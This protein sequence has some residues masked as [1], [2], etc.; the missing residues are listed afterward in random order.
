MLTQSLG[1]TCVTGTAAVVCLAGDSQHLTVRHQHHQPPINGKWRQ[2]WV[3]SW[4]SFQLRGCSALNF[5]GDPPQRWH[6]AWKHSRCANLSIFQALF[7]LKL[8]FVPVHNK[9]TVKTM[10]SPTSLWHVPGELI[11]VHAEKG[12]T[13]FGLL[14]YSCLCYENAAMLQIWFVGLLMFMLWKCCHASNLVCWSTHVYAMKMLSCFKFGLLVYSCLCYENAAMLQIW[15]VGLLMFMLWKC[16]HAS[17]LVCWSTHV[18]AMKMLP[19]FKFGL[20][21]YSCLGY[22]NAAMLQIW[23]VGLLM[24]MLWECCHASNLVCWSTHVYAMRMLPCFKFGLLVYSCLCYENAAMLQIWFVGLL[25]FMLWECC[26]ASNLVC[27]STHVYAMKMLPC[28]KFELLVVLPCLG[29]HAFPWQPF[30]PA[31]ELI[32]AWIRSHKVQ[33]RHKSHTVTL[34]WHACKCKLHK[35]HSTH[36]HARW[37]LP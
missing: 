14:V 37:E 25:M 24:F 30:Q 20:L 27:W 36:A 7:W 12:N 28:F 18:Y 19:C 3:V 31:R 11:Y 2:R 6:V 4:L 29:A 15:F 35:L 33:Q 9:D 16:C 21:V 13:G 32:S 23:F 26:H 17:N 1:V 8:E 22:E 10:S 5:K 34:T